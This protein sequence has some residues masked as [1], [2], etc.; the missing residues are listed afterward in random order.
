MR[1]GMRHV[2]IRQAR[3]Q[4]REPVAAPRGQHHVGPA[5]RCTRDGGQPNLVVA[6]K[7]LKGRQGIPI[8]LHLVS[9]GLQPLDAAPIGRLVP[10]GP[11][12][13]INIDV[14]HVRT[15]FLAIDE[16]G[17]LHAPTEGSPSRWARAKEPSWP[18][19]LLRTK[20]HHQ[21]RQRLRMVLRVPCQP[22]EQRGTAA[23]RLQSLCQCRTGVALP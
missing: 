19:R 5:G 18:L 22:C 8:L 7:A 13:R 6:G 4:P 21:R 11:R 12:R 10:N 16:Q 2:P 1:N 23:A 9:E 15:S 14:R 17:A 20:L 3:Q